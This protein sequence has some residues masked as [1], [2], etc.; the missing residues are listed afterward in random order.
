ML[1]DGAHNGSAT[2]ILITKAA[3][4]DHDAVQYFLEHCGI[5]VTAISGALA[6][7]GKR[8]DLFGVVVLALVTAL[9]GGTLRDVVLDARPVFWVGDT[10]YALTATACALV[11]FVIARSWEISGK[12]LLWADAGGLALFTLLGVEKAL[13]V[14]VSPT[15]AVAM[16]IMTGVAGG[17][18]R[19]VLTGEIPLVFRRQI[20]LYATA[21]LCGALVF[22]LLRGVLDTDAVRLLSAGTTLLLRLA[23][24]QWRIQL[25]D[26]QAKEV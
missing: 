8:V 20:Y 5:A 2:V 26:F 24:I 6:A 25:P 14:G 16:G 18:I 4:E 9:G 11:V 21:S 12:W 3:L 22:V 23:A 15:V 7:R 19:D 17:M 13:R 1:R 10:S